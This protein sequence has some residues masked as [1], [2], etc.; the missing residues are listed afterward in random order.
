MNHFTEKARAK[1]LHE[2]LP[3]NISLVIENHLHAHDQHNIFNLPVRFQIYAVI[4]FSQLPLDQFLS[5]IS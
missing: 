1:K 2:G 4:N 3:F 5:I